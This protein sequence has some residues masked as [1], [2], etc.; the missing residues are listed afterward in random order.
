MLSERR[1]QRN[2]EIQIK[3]GLIQKLRLILELKKFFKNKLKESFSQ[4][5]RPN[6]K[7]N[8]IFK[9]VKKKI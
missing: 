8:M 9:L 6:Q 4:W 1:N 3:K 5:V 2:I 7:I